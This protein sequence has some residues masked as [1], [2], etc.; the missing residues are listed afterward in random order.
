MRGT[1]KRGESGSGARRSVLH[2]QHV[3]SSIVPLCGGTTRCWRGQTG[4]GR[5]VRPTNETVPDHSL[6]VP[7]R[8]VIV[9]IFGI[10]GTV[11]CLI[12]A[13]ASHCAQAD[14]W[15]GISD[16]KQNYLMLKLQ[17]PCGMSG[18]PTGPN[19][20]NRFR[21]ALSPNPSRKGHTTCKIGTSW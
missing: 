12:T 13:S 7:Q 4:T 9:V 1:W 8:P 10:D 11:C 21:R 5:T 3:S 6:R 2:H 18:R 19:R 15:N 16:A 20:W 14:A 17:A